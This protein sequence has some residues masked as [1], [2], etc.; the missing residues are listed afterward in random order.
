MKSIHI[1]TIAFVFFTLLI[2]YL[3]K[4][5]VLMSQDAE[6]SNTAAKFLKVAI[7]GVYFQVLF[8]NF[9]TFYSAVNMNQVPLIII[10]CAVPFHMLALKSVNAF[11]NDPLIGTAI[12]FDITYFLAFSLMLIYTTIIT[13]FEPIRKSVNGLKLQN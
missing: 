13:Y 5:L 2:L 7:P 9:Q 3:D 11:F 4:V 10:I 1:T 8:M 6:V 12:A